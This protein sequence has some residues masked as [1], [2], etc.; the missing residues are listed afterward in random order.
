LQEITRAAQGPQT[1]PLL[2]R[3]ADRPEHHVT[4]ARDQFLRRFLRA[5]FDAP[6]QSVEL[7]CVGI[8]AHLRHSIPPGENNFPLRTRK[9]ALL[10]DK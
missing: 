6:H 10:A 7:G 4:V 9:L 3:A 8:I 5:A 1:S 2:Q